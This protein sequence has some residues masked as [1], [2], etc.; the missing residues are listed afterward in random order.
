MIIDMSSHLRKK[1]LTKRNFFYFIQFCILLFGVSFPFW[2]TT[3]VFDIYH[4]LWIIVPGV[5]F[6]ILFALAFGT[7]FDLNDRAL[8]FFKKVTGYWLAGGFIL[9]FTILF[10]LFI[11]IFLH[12]PQTILFASGLMIASILIMYSYHHAKHIFIHTISLTSSNISQKYTFIQLSDIHI[13]SNGKQEV[14]RILEKMNNIY[15][16]FVVI[17]G[18]LIDEDYA[19]SAALEPLSKI[20]T[21]VYY[22]TGNHEYYLRHTSFKEFIKKTDIVDINDKKVSFNEL[23]IYGI[24]E[25][26]DAGKILD[27]LNI[28]TTKYSIGLMHEP[29][30]QEMQKAEKRGINLMLSGHTHNG[31]IFPFTLMVKARYKFIKGLYQ[32]GNMTLHVSQGTGTW[33]PKMRL[34]TRNEITVINISPEKSTH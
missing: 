34:R 29:K 16:D 20:L 27:S 31:Q 7:I 26:S 12:I 11:N 25:K 19:T 9:F 33:G 1:I 14:Q 13:G 24:D 15:Y 10:L 3:E 28:D 23:D 21:P 5:I 22:I 30:G 8:K 4:P 17:T 6:V 2:Q 18:D 32:L